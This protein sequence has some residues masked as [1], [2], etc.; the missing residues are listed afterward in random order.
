[1]KILGV[2]DL[3]YVKLQVKRLKVLTLASILAISSLFFPTYAKQAKINSED[4]IAVE[5]IYEAQTDKVVLL[6][7]ELDL[8]ELSKTTNSKEIRLIMD[9]SSLMTK[10][11]PQLI[12]IK[13]Y[14]RDENNQESIISIINS[15]IFNRKQA[16]DYKFTL[17]IP[18]SFNSNEVLLD[19]YDADGKLQAS[20]K[21]YIEHNSNLENE[22]LQAANCPEEKFGD[23]QLQYILNAISY[24]AKPS[25]NR[26]AVIT[27]E[28]SGSYTVSL[29]LVKSKSVSFV[30]NLGQGPIIDDDGALGGLNAA[31]VISLVSQGD[32]SFEQMQLKTKELSA[33]SVPADGTLEFDGKKL[34]LV[35]SGKREE[36]GR[37]GDQ[38]PPGPVGATGTF[39]GGTANIS[40]LNLLA[41]SSTPSSPLEGTIYNDNSGAVCIYMNGNWGKLYGTGTCPAGIDSEP[42]VFN[43]HDSTSGAGVL[44]Y[45]NSVLVQNLGQGGISILGDGNPEYS[46]NSGAFTSA[47]GTVNHGDIVRLRATSNGTAGSTNTINITIGSRN[48]DWNIVSSSCPTNFALIPASNSVD[49]FGNPNSN[50]S[51]G[52]CVS[53]YEMTPYD[54]STWTRDGANGWHFNTSSG[55]TKDITAK[56]GA[57]AF[58]ITQVTRN[59]AAAACANR[60]RAADGTVLTNGKLLTIYFWSGIAQ[61][62]VDDG[63]NWSGGTPGSGNLSRGNSSS[64]IAVGLPPMT[65]ATQPTTGTYYYSGAVGRAWRMGIGQDSIYD[66]AGNVGEWFDDLHGASTGSTREINGGTLAYNHSNPFGPNSVTVLPSE[67]ST[68]DNTINGVGRIFVDGSVQFGGTAFSAIFGGGWSASVSSGVFG[69]DWNTYSPSFHRYSAVGFRCII[70]VQ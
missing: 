13:A 2:R 24:Q 41:Q 49:S 35:K 14:T 63:I 62:I 27:K 44:I 34:Y 50:Y 58:P 5:K 9:A 51:S 53:K 6:I 66:F 55:S 7:N 11:Y 67:R 19:V 26:D 46:I 36:L 54:T 30:N 28:T 22:V 61:A 70:P 57:D 10:V 17:N 8:Q 42:D 33:E 12:K 56:N 45:S 16:L 64:A 69:S 20:F 31:Q 1:M 21:Q 47:S 60:L 38:G 68:H 15:T 48:D 23:C 39:S 40:I 59:E 32:F 25:K 52:W 37:Q 29:P 18:A 3:I 65:V 43:F 4:Y